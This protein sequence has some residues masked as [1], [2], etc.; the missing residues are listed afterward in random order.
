MELSQPSYSAAPCLTHNVHTK[1]RS[2]RR[3]ATRTQAHERTQLSRSAHDAH[4]SKMT[5]DD[6]TTASKAEDYVLLGDP[7]K[8]T[9]LPDLPRT[10][11]PADKQDKTI[12]AETPPPRVHANKQDKTVEATHAATY[13]D[14]LK[15]AAPD[16][17]PSV[18]DAAAALKDATLRELGAAREKAS[19]KIKAAAPARRNAPA[20]RRVG[21]WALGLVALAFVFAG[22]FFLGERRGGRRSVVTSAPVADTAPPSA[23]ALAN[24]VPP[25]NAPANEPSADASSTNDASPTCRM[26]ADSPFDNIVN[27][28]LGL[29]SQQPRPRRAEPL[30]AF[31]RR[32]LSPAPR[33]VPTWTTPSAG[34]GSSSACR[35]CGARPSSSGASTPPSPR[36]TK[37]RTSSGGASKNSGALNTRGTRPPTTDRPSKN[38]GASTGRGTRPPTDGPRRRPRSKTSRGGWPRPK[39]PARSASARRGSGRGRG[40]AGRRAEAGT[41]AARANAARARRPREPRHN[42]GTS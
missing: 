30:D 22:G 4:S 20:W 3:P 5:A 12:V 18:G 13:E 31:V 23:N 2:S 6:T 8:T 15:E 40:G 42:R 21:R 1:L 26:R 32:M 14:A 35:S 27:D 17:P 34:P 16:A 7:E 19:T 25:T 36:V 24:H 41:D 38:S 33:V 28:I 39:P 29:R 10:P 37:P 11:E 9:A